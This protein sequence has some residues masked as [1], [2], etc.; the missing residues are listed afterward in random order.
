[1]LHGT[2]ATVLTVAVVAFIAASLL[3]SLTAWSG[4]SVSARTIAEQLWRCAG[5]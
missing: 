2:L 3:R 4:T 5:G 1:M